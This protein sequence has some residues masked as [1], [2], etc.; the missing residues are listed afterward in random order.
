MTKIA[1]PGFTKKFDSCADMLAIAG[2]KVQFSKLAI[3]DF[4]ISRDYAPHTGAVY[5]KMQKIGAAA[6]DVVVVFDGLRA[7]AYSSAFDIP[8]DLVVT[9]CSPEF[10]NPTV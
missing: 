1:N 3:G 7:V 9:A 2:P 6:A 8:E 4:F 10:G 5:F